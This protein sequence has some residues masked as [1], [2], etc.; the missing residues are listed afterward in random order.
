MTPESQYPTQ[1]WLKRVALIGVNLVITA[2]IF[3]Y[4]FRHVRPG[5]VLDLLRNMDLRA[6]AMFVVLSLTASFFRWWRY[7]VL[8][9]LS[10][11]DPPS[12]PLFLMV[13]VRNAFSDLLPARLG[14]LI[15][16]YFFTTRLGVPLPAATS[17]F[18]IT[19]VF[20]ILALSPL[21]A[22]AALGAG[23]SG[24]LPA[25]GLILGGL[26]LLIGTVAVVALLPWAFGFAGRMAGRVLPAHWKARAKTVALC[27][28]TAD[29]I[30]RVW[31]Q[32]MYGRI[33]A[34]S[35]MLR[36][37]KY[38][39]LYVL[40]FAM[41]APLGYT[42]AQL[43]PSRVFLGLCASETAASLPVSGIAGFGV[44]EGA[45]SLVF[46]LLGFPGEIAKA[47][48]IAH[49]LFTQAYGYG[50]GGL[51][52]VIVLLPVFRCRIPASATALA[53]SRPPRFYGAIAA[54]AVL[55]AAMEIGLAHLPVLAS[56]GAKNAD[57]PGPDDLQRRAAFAGAFGGGL[58]FDSSR[59]GSFGIWRM[60]ADG[61]G[62]SVLADTNQQEMYPDP[63]P[64]GRW[65]AYARAVTLSRFSPSEIRVCHPDG[66][67]DRKIADDGTFPTFGPDGQ[68]VYFERNR[69]LVMAA[70]LAGG[71][72]RQVF[73]GSQGFDGQ[74]V[75]PRISPDGK[76][77]TFISDCGGR[78]GWQVWTANL[79]TGEARHLGAGC[80]PGWFPDGARIV[81]VQEQGMKERTG[82]VTRS[83]A[84]GEASMLMDGDAPRGHEYFPVITPDGRW[85]LWGACPP[86]R[87]DHL[88]LDSNY[89]L[90]A[91][92]LPDG[93]PVRLT[94]DGASCR[95]V[96]RLPPMAADPGK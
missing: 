62:A 22:L 28:E 47:T 36:V 2:S 34:L 21:L 35:M 86:G 29:E 75:K 94:F 15:D 40:L 31:R 78:S 30:R 25:G 42:W 95:W 74:V 80:E 20:E 89:Q 92:A 46:Q 81:H 61:S 18:S 50:L 23:A 45:W 93:A 55:V 60:N 32:G 54:V 52:L 96:K 11:Y 9:R 69:N 37:A 65:I 68:T 4:L 79:E 63:S 8:L 5:D 66:S 41:L 43:D 17:C 6:V 72:P 19:F 27:S 3:G 49:H 13:L 1:A 44:Y 83:A 85:L 82:I 12:F 76:R 56:R 88:G 48:S 7:R 33:L 67:G 16:V 73:P 71:E 84:G 53:T 70:S 58:V 77:V 90:F 59:S 51:A 26:L 87:H 64:N 91:R 38:A 57:R 24:T 39:S 10:G 14:T